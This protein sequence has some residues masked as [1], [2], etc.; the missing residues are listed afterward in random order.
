V[1][2]RSD[3]YRETS[4]NVKVCRMT[5]GKRFS[6]NILRIALP[7]PNRDVFDYLP[8]TTPHEA[9]P[10]TRFWVP[11][12]KRKMVGVLVEVA[13]SSQH[14]A[15]KLKKVIEP[16]DDSPALSLELM[17]LLDWASHYY[18]H[19]LGDVIFSALPSILRSHYVITP[20]TTIVWQLTPTGSEVDTTSLQR[21]P[22]QQAL[23]QLLGQHEQ[24]LS[25][26]Q[27]AASGNNWQPTL[28]ALA[29]KGWISAKSVPRLYLEAEPSNSAGCRI[30]LND[31]QLAATQQ[32][33]AGFGRF[34]AFVLEGITGSGKTEVYL[35]SID[36]VINR[37][38][39]ALVLVPEINLTP[40]LAQRFQNRF[41]KPIAVLHSQLTDKQRL[42][43]WLA[44][45]AGEIDVVIGTRSAV[46][47]PFPR[48]G[49]IIIDEEHDSSLKQQEGFRYSA[50]DM[51]VIRARNLGIPI[52]LGSATPSF[53]TLH[54]INLGRYQKLQLT[55]RFGDA[56]LP[57]MRLLDM[58]S[59]PLFEGLSMELADAIGQH[60]K[61]GHQ[62]ILFINR[63]GYAP[64]LLCHD[65]GWIARCQRCDSHMTYH[66]GKRLLRCHHC[67][68][69]RRAE[70][71][72]P[73]CQ[74][75]SLIPL[76]EGTE[77]I[78][79]TLKKQFPEA[80]V[81]R[82]DRDTTRRKGSLENMLQEVHEGGPGILVGTQMLAKGH[83]FPNVTLV[84]ILNIDQGLF[85]VDF[86]ALEKTAQLIVQV[87]G[88]AGRASKP[89]TVLLQTHHPQHPL[90]LTL[91]NSGYNAFAN[92][93]MKERELAALP[94]YSYMAILRSEAVSASLPLQ[95]LQQAK[96]FAQNLHSLSKDIEFLGPLPSPME[97]RAGRYRAQLIIQSMDRATLHKTLT[98][99]ISELEISPLGR[100][101]RWS[102][103]IDPVD[104]F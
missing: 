100:K 84:G 33:E 91:L 80:R 94:P 61:Q 75:G 6:G 52:V 37:G 103:D 85:S 8:V 46:T 101:V 16:L 38:Q 73:E 11:F 92:Q 26:Q 40:Q 89:G 1:V 50:R 45:R 39:Q 14:P 102:I 53:E 69:E 31:E 34:G 82:I 43:A 15:H 19:S 67:G 22:K 27:L 78:E 66:H 9:Y 83:H 76:G 10:G 64:T 49:L 47:T 90:L 25:D 44:A 96:S 51:A 12:G 29:N 97:K 20:P 55:Q 59:Q 2:A 62:I 60:L 104:V 56:Q 21:A 87:A 24:G 13:N 71:N 72:C 81:I 17:K 68:A 54:N 57:G 36:A 79:Q 4:L 86:H 7:I 3:G 88:R 48:L 32:I 58:R 28:K 42:L 35:E 23:V 18:H 98:P 41:S 63:R 99:L 65:C 93:A 95:F 30:A 77:R 5:H 74:G 70:Q